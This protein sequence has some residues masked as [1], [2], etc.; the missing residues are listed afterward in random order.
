MQRTHL[1][2]WQKGSR[3]DSRHLVLLCL[4]G[5]FFFIFCMTVV[6]KLN[7]VH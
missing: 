7:Y 4:A 5:V 3:A 6:C 2:S 1:C